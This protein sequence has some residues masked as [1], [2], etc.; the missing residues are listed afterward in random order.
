MSDNV[1]IVIKTNYVD[2]TWILGVYADA[3]TAHIDAAKRAE[4]GA[5]VHGGE[6]EVLFAGGELLVRWVAA[7]EVRV[8]KY[9]VKTSEDE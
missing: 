4:P 8:E 2:K 5:K 9:P 7:G 6:E 1:F 3:K